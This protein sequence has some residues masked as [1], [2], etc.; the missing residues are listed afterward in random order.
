MRILLKS[1][2]RI[3]NI[4]LIGFILWLASW[5]FPQTVQIDSMRTLVLATI[6]L[7]LITAII[8]IISVIL[9]AVGV[10]NGNVIG[11][12]IAIASFVCILFASVIG[13][14]LLSNHLDGFMVY[15]FLPKILLA[16]CF[17]IFSLRLP[18]R[19]NTSITTDS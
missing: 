8:R 1:L 13:L 5:L 11:V 19:D 6:L 16:I 12:I 15:G 7:W 4:V 2:I 10:V 18:S 9:V 14:V 17:S 3:I